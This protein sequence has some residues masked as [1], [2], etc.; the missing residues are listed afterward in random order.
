MTRKSVFLSYSHKDEEWKN[1]L[2][3]HLKIIE[4]EG[5]LIIW[6]DRKID[7]GDDWLPEIEK[8]LNLADICILLISANYLTSN[9]IKRNEI[10]KILERREKEGLVVIPFILKP[11]AWQKISWLSKILV[12]PQDGR[13]L[14]QGNDYEIENDLSLLTDIVYKNIVPAI[15]S[16]EAKI[17]KIDA[18]RKTNTSQ[19]KEINKTPKRGRPQKAKKLDLPDG[20]LQIA[21]GNKNIQVAGD[22][23]MYEKSSIIK[24]LPSP[25]S[26]GSDTLLK[27]R[28]QT[29]FNKIG[30]EREKRFGKQ[31]YS[32]L[33]KKFKSDF[34]IKNNPWT[35]IWTWPKSCA[36]E[37]ISYLEN[38]YSNT[39]QGR[40][41]K[42]ASRSNYIHTRPQL[43]KKETE[44]L[45]QI[46]LKTSSP[47]VK[48]LLKQYFGVNSHTELKHLQHWLFV[49]Y[50]G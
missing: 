18:F 48:S 43:Y 15:P 19:S 12:L 36:E 4:S 26:I 50:L 20:V 1:R 27:E 39:K 16:K 9:F 34:K 32:V 14:I 31:A 49:K 38:K 35:I 10:P 17:L 25:E 3:T 42:A 24:V 37:I 8:Q 40:I 22:F 30:E 13:P 47:E 11:C 46:G 6:D 2:I 21:S 5:N 41:E 28:I 23:H 33:Y 44:L 45:S 7:I 29:L